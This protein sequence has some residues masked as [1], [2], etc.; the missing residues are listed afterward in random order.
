MKW[1][2]PAEAALVE[3][4]AATMARDNTGA[5]EHLREARTKLEDAIDQLEDLEEDSDG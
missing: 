3:I 2:I 4:T 1:T 5:L